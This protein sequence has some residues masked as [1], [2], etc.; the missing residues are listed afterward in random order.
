MESR[1]KS[2]ETIAWLDVAKGMQR[3]GGDRESYMLILRAYA[4]GTRSLLDSVRAVTEDNLANYA[5]TVHGIKGSSRSI[6]A[7]ATGNMA[8]SLEKAA[9][10]GDFSFV[11]EHNHDFIR[12]VDGLITYI[13][14]VLDKMAAENPKPQKDQ[15]DIETLSELLA[16]CKKYD[17]DGVDEAM[18]KMES[19]EYAS[20]AELGAWLRENVDHMN[21]TQIE[22]RL[23]A[24]IGVVEELNGNRS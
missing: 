1:Q 10:A 18:E 14:D 6:F 7:D 23:S 13:D 19:F 16:A 5:I 12:T 17:M 3:F 11:S 22:E 20:G 9:K 2:D 15:P 8:E 24:L 4:T 21:F